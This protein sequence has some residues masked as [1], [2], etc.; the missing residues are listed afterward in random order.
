[1]K[2]VLFVITIVASIISAIFRFVGVVSANG[3]P[4]E[5]AAA[6]MAAAITI[7]PYCMARSVEALSKFGRE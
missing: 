6:A 5:A 4:Q 2:Y 3:A 1:M 7:I